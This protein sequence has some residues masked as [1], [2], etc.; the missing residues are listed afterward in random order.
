[1]QDAELQLTLPEFAR[2]D[3]LLDDPGEMKVRERLRRGANFGSEAWSEVTSN[4]ISSDGMP[5]ELLF[6]YNIHLLRYQRN[7]P[8]PWFASSQVSGPSGLPDL[9]HLA[10]R[11]PKTTGGVREG[12]S[13]GRQIWRGYKHLVGEFERST[14]VRGEAREE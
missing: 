2:D 13:A 3:V 12:G 6:P 4:A 8:Y 11:R 14:K 10:A 1:M 5:H 7:N 9:T